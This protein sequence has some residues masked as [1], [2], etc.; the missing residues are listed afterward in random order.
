M[1]EVVE[2]SGLTGFSLVPVVPVVSFVHEVFVV[3]DF[4]LVHVLEVDNG[5][6][7]VHE[8]VE[9]VVGIIDVEVNSQGHSS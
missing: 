9:V 5:V 6:V 8:V 2:V 7:L 4:F 1:H 3:D